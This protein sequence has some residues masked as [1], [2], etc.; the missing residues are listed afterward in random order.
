VSNGNDKDESPVIYTDVETL[1][2][3]SQIHDTF[4]V[5]MHKVFPDGREEDLLLWLPAEIKNAQPD[6]LRI[7][8]FYERQEECYKKYG[9]EGKDGAWK[10]AR[11]SSGCMLAGCRIHFD[12]DMIRAYLLKYDLKPAWGIY[13]MDVTVFAAGALGLTGRFSA[14][15]VAE[16]LKV[17][18]PSDDERHTAMGDARL[19]KRIHQ[20]ALKLQSLETRRQDIHER[21]LPIL[22][23]EFNQ[24]RTGISDSLTVEKAQVWVQ[25]LVPEPVKTSA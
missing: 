4:E 5:G 14:K 1:G 21:L 15:R 20:A 8:R 6:A 22:R 13:T 2:L 7:N 10:I 17:E 23:E 3:E 16:L 19:A 18:M 12:E 9:V 25:K 11:F 24:F